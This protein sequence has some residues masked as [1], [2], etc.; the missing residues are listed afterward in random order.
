M[1]INHF[2]ILNLSENSENA[3]DLKDLVKEPLKA[4][5]APLSMLL[6]KFI[7]KLLENNEKAADDKKLPVFASTSHVYTDAVE[8]SLKKEESLVVKM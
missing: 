1:F 6:K 7:K 8:V 4:L 3:K 5:K 2:N